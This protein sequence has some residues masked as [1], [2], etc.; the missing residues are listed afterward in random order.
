[1]HPRWRWS[2]ISLAAIAT[3]VATFVAP[4]GGKTVEVAAPA[5]RPA[6]ATPAV[7]R[8][9]APAVD[10][11][12]DLPFREPIGRQRGDMFATRSWT[13]KPAVAQKPEAPKPPPNPYRFAGTVQHDGARKV[14]LL[15]G[16]RVFEAKEGETLEQGFRV[17]SV[18]EDA[19]TLV[20]VP[21]DMPV[22]MA[23]AFQEAPAPAPAAAGA[24]AP[25][26]PTLK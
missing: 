20:Y 19:V 12:V 1:V 11:V 2:L 24:T 23:L 16:D 14:F 25:P 26:L 3:G 6:E 15:L 18:T 13:P 9:P 5:Q 10:R 22:K 7:L 21:L 4:D 17:Q 8:Q